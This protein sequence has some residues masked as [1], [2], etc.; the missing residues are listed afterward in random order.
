MRGFK[1][2]LNSWK[3]MPKALIFFAALLVA[4]IEIFPFVFH[5]PIGKDDYFFPKV[6]LSFGA[7]FVMCFFG[8]A[9]SGELT[10]NKLVRSMPIAKELY[11][12]SVPMVIVLCEA[13]QTVVMLGY[14]VFL[15]AKGA[16]LTQFSDTLIIGAIVSGSALLVMPAA[17]TVPMGTLLGLYL[18][19]APVGVFIMLLKKETKLNGLNAPLP[20]AIGVYAAA[21]VIGSVWAFWISGVR[22]KRSNVKVYSNVV[23]TE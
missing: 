9:V 17:Y 3:R 10:A 18:N 15:G 1:F 21:L 4:A 11:T 16:E 12:R 2:M 23:T 19:I 14:F 8:I 13:A 20:L 7:V 22:F 6:F 5:E